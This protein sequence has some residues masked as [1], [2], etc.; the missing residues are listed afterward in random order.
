MANYLSRYLIGELLQIL[1]ENVR[2][3]KFIRIVLYSK[4]RI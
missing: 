4:K 3:P 1:E 2:M